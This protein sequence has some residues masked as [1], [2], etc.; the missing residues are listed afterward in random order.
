MAALI[1]LAGDIL[2]RFPDIRP[3]NVVAHSDVAPTRKMDPGELFD[4][5]L[6]AEYGIGLWP[7]EADAVVLDPDAVAEMLSAFGYCHG[8]TASPPIK[9]FQRHFRP[10]RVN[11]RIDF[12]TVRRLAGLLALCEAAGNTT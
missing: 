6:L 3:R 11:G 7:D 5:R 9:A 2:A 4:W 1:E 12:E 8:R 10:E